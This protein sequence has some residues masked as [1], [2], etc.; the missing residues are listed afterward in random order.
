MCVFLVNVCLRVN[1]IVT[2]DFIIPVSVIEVE[3]EAEAAERQKTT[4]LMNN[5]R[6]GDVLQ[7]WL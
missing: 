5:K 4:T 3:E 1:A 2:H 6:F 7:S